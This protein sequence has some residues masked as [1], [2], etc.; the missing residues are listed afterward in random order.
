MKRQLDQVYSEI[1]VWEKLAHRNV[2]MIFQLLD[3]EDAAFMYLVM[4]YCNSGQILNYDKKTQSYVRNPK[5]H[6]RALG[7][8]ELQYLD[9]IDAPDVE[10]AAKFIFR[11]VAEGLQY[12]HTEAKVAHRDIKPDNIFYNGEEDL[13]RVKIGDYTLAVEIPD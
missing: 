10:K 7:E 11:Q 13:E 8:A 5:V 9:M 1:S 3:A 2:V 12:L 6:E 4:Q